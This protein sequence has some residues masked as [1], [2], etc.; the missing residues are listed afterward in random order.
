MGGKDTT[1]SHRREVPL[2]GAGRS[3]LVEELERQEGGVTFIHM[4]PLHRGI[5]EGLE[6][7]DAA[8]AQDDFLREP[9]AVI[10]SVEPQA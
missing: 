8:N 3:R 2:R 10:P 4:E 7:L 6:H 9:V 1:P 5:P